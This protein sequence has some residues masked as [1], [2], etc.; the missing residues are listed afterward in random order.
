MI[1]SRFMDS[2]N[3][4]K[5]QQRIF[6]EMAELEEAEYQRLLVDF[7]QAGKMCGIDVIAEIAEKNRP[8]SE[9]VA[10]V[11]RKQKQQ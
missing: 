7:I 10:E 4:D 1:E 11:R 9:V 5:F 8:V 3:Y 2:N 6:D